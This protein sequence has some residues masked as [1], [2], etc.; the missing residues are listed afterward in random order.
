MFAEAESNEHLKEMR[1][2]ALDIKK[3][4]VKMLSEWKEAARELKRAIEARAKRA[5]R[6]DSAKAKGKA[7]GRTSRTSA[8]SKGGTSLPAESQAPILPCI[9]KAEGAIPATVIDAPGELSFEAVQQVIQNT[10]DCD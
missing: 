2:A 4:A 6:E 1:A 7:A 8:A 9:Y 5:A 3:V 10:K